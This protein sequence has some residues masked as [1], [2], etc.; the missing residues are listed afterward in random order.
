MTDAVISPKKASSGLTPSTIRIGKRYRANRLNGDYDAIVIGSGIGG[1]TAAA[2]LSSFGYKVAVFEQHYT[3]GGFTHSYSRNGYEWDVG[4]HYI[5]DVGVKTTLARRLFDFISNDQLQWQAMDPC[6][7]RIHLG[8]DHFDLIAGR[9]NFR[10]NLVQRFPQEQAAIDEYIVRLGKVAD[11][12]QLFTVERMLPNK[13]AKVS[14][15]VRDRIKPAYFNQP[16]RQVLEELTS[17]QTLIAYLTGQWGDN[18]MMPAESSFLI[19]ALIA[20]HYLYG[21]YYPIGGASRM[22]ETI[23]PQI[24][25][26]GG[27]VFTYASVEKILLENGKA[28]GVRMK[29]GTDVRS[30][31]VISNAGVVNTF[32][33]LLPSEVSQKTGYTQKMKQVR[34]SMASLCL[35]IG[36]K[37][38][39]E[40]LK[41]PKTN[42]WIYPNENYEQSIK[43]FL[44]DPKKDIPM[45]YISFP[46]AKDP[47]FSERYPDRSTIEIVAPCPWEWVEQWADKPWGKR[48]A[49]YD[50]LKEQ[51]TQRLLEKL[52]EKMPHLRGKVDYSELSTPL[53]TQFFC[54]YERGEIYG[55]DHDPQRFEQTWLR[56]KTTIDGLYLT[57]QD[58]MTCGVVGAM[59][60]GLMTAVTIG[61]VKALPLAK[62]IF[63][64]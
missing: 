39:A 15:F 26:T 55:L 36:I 4:V 44:A 50:E 49:D 62:K 41:L 40:D 14:K 60:G 63:V 24:Q 30:P 10:N 6:Y 7:D 35:Y 1:L 42:F 59:I 45:V 12:M 16:T 64:G 48:G 51:F 52:Y 38:T 23:I 28:V 9:D 5:G 25:K 22:A 43:G 2:C 33:R 57:G 13:L 53:S 11:A 47:S 21:G 54:W 27:E 3:A 56:P 20:K 18:G 19:H 17:N 58:I 8:D 31:I 37:E 34:P 61:G 29:D 32:N 46:S